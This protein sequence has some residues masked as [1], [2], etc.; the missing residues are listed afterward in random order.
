MLMNAFESQKFQ[1]LVSYL[2]IYML[3]RFK[4]VIEGQK[5][6]TNC[7]IVD[8]LHIYRLVGHKTYFYM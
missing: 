7:L 6:H 1:V 8:K 4:L 3:T 5:Q 2:L